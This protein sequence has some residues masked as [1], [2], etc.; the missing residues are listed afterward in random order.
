MPPPPFQGALSFPLPAGLQA[1]VQRHM[2]D[3]NLRAGKPAPS[4]LCLTC[5]NLVGGRGAGEMSRGSLISFILYQQS[6]SGA[7]Q[8]VGDVFSALMG[9]LG[10]ADKVMQLMRRQPE[11][12]GGKVFSQG[13][14]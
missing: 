10:A 7:F 4:A 14:E 8:M 11:V 5:S 6:L 2:S 9:A 13:G 12:R 1:C 3:H